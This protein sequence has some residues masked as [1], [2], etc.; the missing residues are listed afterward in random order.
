[1]P[2]NISPSS[3]SKARAETVAAPAD[4]RRGLN[5]ATAANPQRQTAV[6]KVAETLHHILYQNAFLGYIDESDSLYRVWTGAGLVLHVPKSR[7]VPELYPLKKPSPLQPVF[8]WLGLALLGL[9]LAGLGAFIGLFVA[10]LY[11]VWAYRQPLD[12]ADQVRADVAL[13]AMMVLAGVAFVLALLL[14]FHL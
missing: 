5:R 1:M 2:D 6:R 8:R 7:A 3:S 13:L 4:S 10:L 12:Q 9:P 14:V 11:A